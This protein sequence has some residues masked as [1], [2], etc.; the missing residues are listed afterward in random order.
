MGRP[1]ADPSCGEYD[2]RSPTARTEY[3]QRHR[4]LS[5]MTIRMSSIRRTPEHDDKHRLA[6]GIIKINHSL[7]RLADTVVPDLAILDGH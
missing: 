2:F 7:A 3:A 1:V 5:P 6:Q 4:P